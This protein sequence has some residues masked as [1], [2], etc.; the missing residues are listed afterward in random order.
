MKVFFVAVMIFMAMPLT[1]HPPKNIE[2][3]YD[4]EAGILS[5][6]IAHSVNDPLKHFINK[7]VVEVNGKKHVEQYFKKQ[8]DGENQRALY[9]I[10]DA[11][12]GSS[13][14]VI[15]YCNISGRRK[16]DLEV[17]LKKDEVIED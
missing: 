3:D 1:G 8:A 4:A 13:L 15:A 10:I 14:T 11:E 5:I 7:V 9:K 12:E 2:L 6:E 16:A 17:T